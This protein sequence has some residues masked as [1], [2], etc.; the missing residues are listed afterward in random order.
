MAS[1]QNVPM[2]LGSISNVTSHSVVL[3]TSGKSETGVSTP[4]LSLFRTLL[5]CE[6]RPLARHPHIIIGAVRVAS[7]RTRPATPRP[8]AMTILHCG[9][10]VG[11]VWNAWEAFPGCLIN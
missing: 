4:H 6:Y 11:T 9:V 10:K 5:H 2:P 7:P 3:S 8:D 1:H